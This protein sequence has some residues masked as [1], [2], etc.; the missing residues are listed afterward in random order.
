MHL[1]SYIILMIIKSLLLSIY[2][3]ISSLPQSNND[4]IVMLIL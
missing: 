2:R 3:P 4:S 1:I